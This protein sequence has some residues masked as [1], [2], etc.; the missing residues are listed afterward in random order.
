MNTKLKLILILTVCGAISACASNS[1]L[2]RDLI[3]Q[4][5]IQTVNVKQLD[6]N[7]SIQES[8]SGLVIGAV[9]G[10]LIGGAIGSAVDSNIN[11]GRKKNFASTQ[12]SINNF[13][14]NVILKN[15]LEHKLLDGKAFSDSVVI[16]TGFD[17]SVKKPYLIPVLTPSIVMSSSYDVVDITLKVTTAQKSPRNTENQHK[18][19]Y[20]SQQLIDNASLESGKEENKQYW[21]DNP[22]I[23]KEKIVNGL[24]DVAEQFA[25][26][27][28]G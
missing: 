8:S 18:S 4:E 14:V 1:P 5:K 7:I 26:D 27:F 19:T 3:H 24:Y 11:S 9:A 16:D 6:E 12:E 21:I 13:N 23:L 17:Q 25:D 20:S 2:N 15:A 28:N 22:I 10:G